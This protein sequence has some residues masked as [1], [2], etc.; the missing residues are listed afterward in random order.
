MIDGG[1]DR[2]FVVEARGE[3]GA[4]DRGVCIAE[5]RVQVSPP[6][7]CQLRGLDHSKVSS[8]KFK[9][10][11]LDFTVTCSDGELSL[12]RSRVRLAAK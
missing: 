3:T 12:V 9:G 8:S 10:L 4:L 1:F 11:N 5:L 6:W 2:R 7:K